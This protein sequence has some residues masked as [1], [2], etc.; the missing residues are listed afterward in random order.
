MLNHHVAGDK[1]KRLVAKAKI[2]QTA[3]D[4][5]DRAGSRQG[6]DINVGSDD[7]LGRFQESLLYAFSI[8]QPRG[9]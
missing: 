7:H 5:P 9:Y 3:S 8:T 2:L 6:R 1:V 4:A